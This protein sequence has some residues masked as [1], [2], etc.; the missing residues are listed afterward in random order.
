MSGSIGDRFKIR[1]DDAHNECAY[2][3]AAGASFRLKSEFA[4]W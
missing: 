4:A 2:D 1:E 3:D